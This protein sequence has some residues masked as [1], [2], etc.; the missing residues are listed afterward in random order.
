MKK[1]K[2][3]RDQCTLGELYGVII[4]ERRRRSKTR[5]DQ[6]EP[7]GKERSKKVTVLY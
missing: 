7:E 3:N 4:E 1:P 5:K 2:L 6:G